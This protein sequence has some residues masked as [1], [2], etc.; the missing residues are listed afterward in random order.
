MC[1]ILFAHD[2]H[3]HYR[4]ILA[5]NRDEYYDRATLP[6]QFWHENLDILAG[7]DQVSGGTWLGINRRGRWSAVTNFRN[8]EELQA[9]EGRSRGLLVHDYL[10]T[11]KSPL[12]FMSDLNAEDDQYSGYN[13]L[14]SNGQSLC[15]KSNR[16]A[17]VQ[18]LSPGYYG[19]SNHLL[20]TPW[21]KLRSSKVEFI[22][23]ME[24]G[25]LNESAL[26]DIL[27]DTSMPPDEQLPDTGFGLDLERVLSPRFI[28]SERY[29]TRMSSLL[30]I[31]REGWVTF[32]ERT[33]DRSPGNWRE[34]RVLF[35]SK[36]SP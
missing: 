12:E 7:K 16:G 34:V 18:E 21:P 8:Q 13:L 22:K 27:V 32:V 26:F 9:S 4:L 24:T 6:V 20:D 2:I 19:L 10:A 5:A 33:F 23:S 3:P 28:Q 35:K 1:L 11:D 14:V 15:F 30:L 36:P 25:L 31:D 29:G 17:P